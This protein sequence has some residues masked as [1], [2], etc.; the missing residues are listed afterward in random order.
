MHIVKFL[1]AGGV[2]REKCHEKMQQILRTPMRKHDFS[3]VAK[4]IY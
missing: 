4:Q 2:F 3:E 1:N